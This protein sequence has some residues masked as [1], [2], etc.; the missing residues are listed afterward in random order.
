M[1][2]ALILMLFMNVAVLRMQGGLHGRIRECEKKLQRT[3]HARR[4]RAKLRMLLPAAA[5]AERRA[6]CRAQLSQASSCLRSL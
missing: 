1:Q 6:A 5:D 2:H 4:L 3:R